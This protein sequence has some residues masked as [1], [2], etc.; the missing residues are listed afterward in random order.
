[1]KSLSHD[2]VWGHSCIVLPQKLMS[3]A[4]H[5]TGRGLVNGKIVLWLDYYF[6]SIDASLEPVACTGYVEFCIT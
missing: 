2:C 1:M 4:E 6:G 5:K 3:V